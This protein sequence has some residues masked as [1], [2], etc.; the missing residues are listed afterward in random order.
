MKLSVSLA[1]ILFFSV[2][3]N[4][5]SDDSASQPASGE[6]VSDLAELKAAN[7]EFVKAFNHR[8]ANAIADMWA[9]DGDYIDETGTRYAGREAIHSE[10]ER[11]FNTSYGR[12]INLHA[13]S[14]R[15]LRPDIVLIDGTSEVDPAPAGKPVI[16][17]FSAIRVKQDGK[18]LLTS[19]RESAVEVPSN[20]EHLTPL[21]WMIGEWV[22]EDESS[23]IHTSAV[24]SKNKNFIIRQFKVH[25]NG[26]NVLSGTQRIGWDPIRKQIKS[27]TFDSDGGVAEGHWS[28][29]GDQWFVQKVSVLQDG[30][31][32]SATNI[33]TINDDNDSFL[34]ESKN[35]IVGN[36]QEPDIEQVKVIRLPPA[37]DP[38]QVN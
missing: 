28:H 30:T 4:I 1:L 20:Y 31:R 38:N 26:R 19:V 37:I 10:F 6:S 8:D 14:I 21:E 29:H 35:R 2:A 36:E 22:D 32:A 7:K 16:G 3:A 11:Y 15:F 27:W 25:L 33:Y 13:S 5:F 24:W 18:W 34:W 12:K 9:E 23:S 17:R